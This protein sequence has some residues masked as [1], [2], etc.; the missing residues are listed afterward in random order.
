ML[1]T[2]EEIRSPQRS[3]RSGPILAKMPCTIMS[4]FSSVCGECSEHY[5]RR[6]SAAPS[7]LSCHRC[8]RG[9]HDCDALK[10]KLQPF[11]D[12]GI[13]ALLFSRVFEADFTGP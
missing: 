5:H 3:S 10:A 11:L 2:G 9:S 1:S 4:L 8:F 7:L 13:R 6:L 12:L